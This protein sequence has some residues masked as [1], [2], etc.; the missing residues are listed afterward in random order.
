[1]FQLN[2]CVLENHVNIITIQNIHE[3]R[4]K[5]KKKRCIYEHSSYAVNIWFLINRDNDNFKYFINYVA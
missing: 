4:T 2:E 5:P 1:M 3:E